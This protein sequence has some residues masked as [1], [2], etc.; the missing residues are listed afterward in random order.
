VAAEEKAPP[1]PEPAPKEPLPIL[2]LLNTVALLAAVGFFYYSKIL[3]K[4]PQITEATEREK[5][6][7]AHATPPVPLVAT[8]MTF[9]PMTVNIAASPNQPRA[10]DGTTQQIQG[11]MHYVTIGFALEIRDKNQQETV[12]LLRPQIQDKFILI[13]G[14]K[15][16]HELTN[17]QGRYVLHSQII[18]AV[19][20]IISAANNH[21]G[22]EGLI[23]NVF[24]TEFT[25][26]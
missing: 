4:R 2:P 7:S 21:S 18:E 12:A 19:N 26:Q 25:V 10:A 1:S 6:I 23:T 17:V 8:L 9:E 20:Q 14:K 11:K 24:F 5:L 16:Y 15:Y 22:K 13:L 3:Y